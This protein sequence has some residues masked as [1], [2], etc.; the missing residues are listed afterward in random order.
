MDGAKYREI[1]LS[2]VIPPP[3]SNQTKM[4]S[5]VCGAKTFI[6]RYHFKDIN[7]RF[8][9]SSKVPTFTKSKKKKRARK[10]LA[11]QT[12]TNIALS[13]NTN[14][15]WEGGNFILVLNASSPCSYDI[16]TLWGCF[17]KKYFFKG[18]ASL[19]ASI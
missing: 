16:I 17:S 15:V 18:T 11:A 6:C 14:F 3:S 5:N 7:E 9:R 12:S 8:Q 10:L 4:V 1:K 19:S 2:E 13:V